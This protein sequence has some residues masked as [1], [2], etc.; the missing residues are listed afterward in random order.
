MGG[1]RIDILN[2]GICTTYEII[3]GYVRGAGV[4]VEAAGSDPLSPI[5]FYADKGIT[6]INV[7]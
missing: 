5:V 2:Q 3:T 4:N 6:K 7:R 1:S